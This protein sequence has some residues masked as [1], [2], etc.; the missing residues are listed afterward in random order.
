MAD[1]PALSKLPFLT[2]LVNEALRLQPPVSSGAQRLAP[3]GGAILCDTYIAEGT[4]TRIPAYV[5]HRDP[6]YFSNPD[7]FN[8]DRWLPSSTEKVHDKNAFFPFLVGPYAC[9]GKQVA[10]HEMRYAVAAIVR[11]FDLELVD[12]GKVKGQDWADL[13]EDTLLCEIKGPLKTRL[14]LRKA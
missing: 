5:V 12:D 11:S 10:L 13:I 7:Q 6:R 1:F 4:A 3:P 9:I 2:A 8:P 14:S